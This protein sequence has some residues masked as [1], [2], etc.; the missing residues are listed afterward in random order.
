MGNCINKMPN[1]KKHYNIL[2]IGTKCSGQTSILYCLKN[3]NIKK[4]RILTVP[5]IGYNY[6]SINYKNNVFNIW[7]IGSNENIPF[8]SLLY[9]CFYKNTD[10]IIFVLDS[11]ENLI[12][13][14]KILTDIINDVN[15]E[16][17]N[18]IENKKLP[19]LILANKQDLPNAEDICEIDKLFDFCDHTLKYGF[20]P[21]KKH[22]LKNSEYAKDDLINIISNI[23]NINNNKIYDNISYH[24]QPSSVVDN[25]GFADGLFWLY[26]NL[27]K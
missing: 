19:I 2:M 3:G 18:K 27:N 16:N 24:V 1:Y 17:F 26:E 21:F 6:D 20:E 9:K 23:K 11:T 25:I 12:Y 14:F 7:D 10:A 4:K 8:N 5:T 22:E 15:V 13:P